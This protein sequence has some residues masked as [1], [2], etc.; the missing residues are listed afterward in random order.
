MRFYGDV[1]ARKGR[2][3][4]IGRIKR[5]KFHPTEEL[6]SLDTLDKLG[7]K[8]VTLQ[9]YSVIVGLTLTLKQLAEIRKKTGYTELWIIDQPPPKVTK[10]NDVS[11]AQ[12]DRWYFRFLHPMCQNCEKECKQSSRVDLICPNFRQK[13]N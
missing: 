13:K 5:G 7:T 9:E 8:Y 10:T 4:W 12:W 3:Y 2:K 6:N 1:I 11:D